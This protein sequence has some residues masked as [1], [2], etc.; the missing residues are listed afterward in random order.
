MMNLLRA[1]KFLLLDMA[2]TIF[3]LIVYL[4]TSNIA[5][6]IVLGVVLGFAQIGWSLL[7]R[8]PVDA[9]QWLSLFLVVA[10][11]SATLVTHDPRFVMVK[12]S[13]IY[14]IVG[15]VMLKPGW[16]NRYLPP[17]AMTHLSDVASVFG[18]VWAALMFVS[19]GVNLFVAINFSVTTWASFMSA[20]GPI[21][22]IG[23]FLVQYTTMRLIGARRAASRAP[24]AVP[25]LS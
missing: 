4:F 12:P 15:A 16:M 22:K 3:F 6:S 13:L 14:A 2:S 23:L 9:M 10:A 24:R 11:G 25:S 8:Q 7:R 18:F 17:E 21:T 5:V 20:Y 19:A 1:A